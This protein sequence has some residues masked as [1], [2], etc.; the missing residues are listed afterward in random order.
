MTSEDI[1]HQLIIIIRQKI[2]SYLL[3]DIYG[4]CVC[5]CTHACVCLCKCVSVHAY[6]CVWVCTHVRLCGCVCVCVCVCAC[7]CVGGGIEIYIEVHL[8]AIPMLRQQFT[9]WLRWQVHCAG[10]GDRIMVVVKCRAGRFTHCHYITMWRCSRDYLHPVFFLG[11]YLPDWNCRLSGSFETCRQTFH[12]SSGN[13][14]KG[15]AGFLWSYSEKCL[16]FS[17]SS[18]YWKYLLSSPT[19]QIY[20][21]ASESL[22]HKRLKSD[23][24]EGTNVF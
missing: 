16:P 9:G 6:A 24:L 15:I 3:S 11:I 22:Q 20:T 7:V 19:L 21:I 23:Y 17:T 10:E 13:N 5:V 18:V 2:V 4:V 12:C 1:K 14:L 8:F